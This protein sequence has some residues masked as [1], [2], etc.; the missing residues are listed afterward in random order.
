MYE[1]QGEI[2]ALL[3]AIERNTRDI[4]DLLEVG[5]GPQLRRILSA[6]TSDSRKRMVYEASDGLA[7][8]REIASRAGVSDRTVRDWWHDWSKAGLLRP[9]GVEGRFIKKYDLNRLA[10]GEEATA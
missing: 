7:S 8:S 4:A 10:L 9:A 5:Y 2:V 3:R 6:V 1:P